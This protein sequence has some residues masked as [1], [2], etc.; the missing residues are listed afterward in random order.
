MASNFI[1]DLVA[2]GVASLFI[3]IPLLLEHWSF[4]GTLAEFFNKIKHFFKE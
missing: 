2:V 1:H 4:N 3:I